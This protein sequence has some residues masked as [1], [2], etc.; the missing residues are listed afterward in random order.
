MSNS[1]AEDEIYELPE[2]GGFLMN[3]RMYYMAG[4]AMSAVYSTTKKVRGSASFSPFA[5]KQLK[6]ENPGELSRE[7]GIA[8]FLETRVPSFVAA[9]F[10]LMRGVTLAGSAYVEKNSLV[11]QHIHGM[12][13]LSVTS[14]KF[15]PVEL[16][17]I[18]L[19]CV[20][21]Y[22]RV[23]G[24]LKMEDVNLENVMLD[25]REEGC[26]RVKF[27][28]FGFWRENI[29]TDNYFSYYDIMCWNLSMEA[30]PIKHLLRMMGFDTE[31]YKRLF[32]NNHH[33]MQQDHFNGLAERLGN[34]LVGITGV[35]EIIRT[36]QF[37]VVQ[38][39]CSIRLLQLQRNDPMDVISEL[40]NLDL[41]SAFSQ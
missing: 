8:H 10:T 16:C 34:F 37:T 27:I 9:P 28:D 12:Q 5:V 15:S 17:S 4:G 6:C 20:E 40:V 32:F 14:S 3:R 30:T 13:I 38:K 2:R 19:Q 29:E 31:I 7:Y 18:F 33:R 24:S 21:F 11:Q 1:D 26:P 25:T 22:L 36:D 23:G 41:R 35:N 39:L